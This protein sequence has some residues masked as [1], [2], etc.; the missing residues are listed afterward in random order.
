[1]DCQTARKWMSPY[2]DSELETA[3]TFEINEHLR[4]CENC[5]RRF[6]A[7]RQVDDMMRDRLSRETMPAETW[8]QLRREVNRSQLIAK[9]RPLGIVAAAASVVLVAMIYWLPGKNASVPAPEVFAGQW[10]PYVHEPVPNGSLMTGSQIAVALKREFGVTFST[11]DTHG[12]P[13]HVLGARRVRFGDQP[14][15][16]VRLKCCGQSAVITAL[17][18]ADAARMPESLRNIA[19]LPPGTSVDRD[20]VNVLVGVAGD[21]EYFIASEHHLDGLVD[22]MGPA[23]QV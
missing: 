11:R 17:R 16:E 18:K 23:G 1:M 15:I 13:V 4:R 19:D 20:G 12:H 22:V 2:L 9:L 14:A 6:D 7:E 10:K 3:K 5:R 8:V 21:A